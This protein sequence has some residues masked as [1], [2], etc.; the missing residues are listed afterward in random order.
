MAPSTRSSS[1]PTRCS[2]PGQ[3]S[4]PL[5]GSRALFWTPGSLVGADADQQ[6]DFYA[7]TST[8]T[9][10]IS[11]GPSGGNAPV[12]TPRSILTTPDGHLC[13]RDLRGARA[14][15]RRPGGL[16]VYERTGGV[17]TLVTA[18][19]GPNNGMC[20]V[21]DDYE[22]DRFVPCDMTL[23]AVSDDGSHVFFR[24]DASLDPADSGGSDTY[25]RHNG[26]TRRVSRRRRG[27]R[28][29]LA[30]WDQG[31]LRH[32][33]AM[34][35]GR[36]RTTASTQTPAAT[37][38]TCGKEIPPRCSRPGPHRRTPAPTCTTWTC[39][40]TASTPS[41]PDGSLVA[42][43]ADGGWFDVYEY[44]N[45][46]VRLVSAGGNGPYH[47]DG[48]WWYTSDDGSHTAFRTSERLIR[49]TPTPR[50]TC[51]SAPGVRQCS[52]RPGHP[53]ATGPSGRPWTAS[54]G[55]ARASSSTPR[56]NSPLKTRIPRA[57]S[58]SAPRVR[59]G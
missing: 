20:V 27:S 25:E 38:S 16:D 9:D 17:T 58:M 7:R 59:R 21:E 41:S 14:G 37:T 46:A 43:D 33:G 29:D 2:S 52:C 48:W 39:R 12:D 53:A 4:Y 54:A 8:G 28:G 32:A 23:S 22:P 6:T 30:G 49:R 57:T 36:A 47:A 50:S 56:S 24:T 1:P 42:E 10:L 11:T 31:L 3:R 51:T 15:G 18:D 34:V 5:D 40:W 45:A 19:R 55:M 35:A 13:S 44:S 26:Q